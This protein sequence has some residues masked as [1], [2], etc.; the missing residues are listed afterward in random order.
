MP[1]VD[2]ARL[3]ALAR[4]AAPATP[5]PATEPS[6]TPTPGQLA[7][8]AKANEKLASLLGKKE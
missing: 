3:E 2:Q 1:Q 6:P 8:L 7:D 5:T 4:P